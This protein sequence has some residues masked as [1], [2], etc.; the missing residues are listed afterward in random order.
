[1]K[2]HHLSLLPLALAALA[3][4]GAAQAQSSLTVYGLL[5]AG[6]TWTNNRASYHGGSSTTVDTGVAQGSRLG[7]KG[8]E[9]LGEG[10]RANFVL[11]QGLNLDTGSLGQG[12]LAWGRQASVGLAGQFGEVSLGRMFDVMGEVFPAY[13]IGSNTPAGSMAWSLP[14]YS[15][16]GATLVNRVYGAAVDNSIRYRSPK[17]SGFSLTTTYSMGEQTESIVTGGTFSGALTYTG[18]NFGTSIGTY[19]LRNA[20]TTNGDIAEYALG[21][22]VQASPDVRLFSMASQVGYSMGSK[23]KVTTYEVGMNY[24]LNPKLVLGSGLQAQK[25]RNLSGAEQLTLTLDYL[26]S[27]RT[28]VYATVASGKDREY[29]ALVVAALGSVSEGTS[30]TGLRVGIR[31]KF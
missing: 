6:L 31:H 25:R 15:A 17:V 13:A 21:A 7:F 2:N 19:Q 4:A 30:Q 29:G 12:G 8:S 10:L 16:G 9:D 18:D 14:M 22:Y 27:K 28:D 1:M 3:C 11:E 26:L 20:S 5:D 23:A 24:N